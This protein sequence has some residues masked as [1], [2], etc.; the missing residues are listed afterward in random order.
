MY[1]WG[2]LFMLYIVDHRHHSW[3]ILV[4]PLPHGKMSHRACFPV[5]S[6]SNIACFLAFVYIRLGYPDI[7]VSF[8]IPIKINEFLKDHK[9]NRE[10]GDM[11]SKTHFFIFQHHKGHTHWH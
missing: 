8:V 1:L 11:L 5:G 7:C 3:L 9:V 2:N 4:A 6:I 10:W